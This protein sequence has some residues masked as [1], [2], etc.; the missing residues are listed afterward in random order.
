MQGEQRRVGWVFVA[1]ALTISGTALASDD[2]IM[3]GTECVTNSNIGA[4]DPGTD[5]FYALQSLDVWCPLAKDNA[6]LAPE[7]VYIRV[8]ETGWSSSD[9]VTCTLFASSGTALAS[10]D[11]VSTTTNGVGSLPINVSTMSSA[12]VNEGYVVRCSLGNGD[13]V[14]SIKF[15]EPG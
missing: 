13:R 7:N 15:V 14:R 6:A 1:T 2:K 5:G 4:W 10:S 9:K 12:N 11:P 3:H 8:F